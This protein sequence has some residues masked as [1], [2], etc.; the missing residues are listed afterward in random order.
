[1][2]TFVL[3]HGAGD[4]GWSWHLVE[5]AL[6]ARGHDVVAPDLPS[7]DDT[8]TYP[9]YAEVV[10]KAIGDRTDLV[11]AGHSLGGFTAPLVADRTGARLI[12]MVSGMIPRPGE[13]VNDWWGNTGHS[14]LVYEPAAGD[15]ENAQFYHDVPADLVAGA[16]SRERRQSETP[17]DKPWPLER[18]PDVPTRVLIGGDDR[19]MPE[20]W[21][22]KVA[23]D[24]LGVEADAIE[25]GGHCIP[26]SRPEEV[27][28]YL[29]RYAAE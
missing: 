29:E 20:E 19:F 25:G 10:V 24:R 5:A 28:D 17:M 6:R 14:D 11:I 27:A 23:R 26:L 8:A 4:A 12:V 15:D 9:D 22:R 3:I 18:W 16:L 1:M 2:T 21:S 7:D 13:S